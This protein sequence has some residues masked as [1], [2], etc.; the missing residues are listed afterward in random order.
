MAG[1]DFAKATSAETKQIS[2]VP[3]EGPKVNIPGFYYLLGQIG[4][5]EGQTAGVGFVH[6]SSCDDDQLPGYNWLANHGGCDIWG[7]GSLAE[8]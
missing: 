8:I 4:G 1:L 7:K 5:G 3:R 6:Q 2:K